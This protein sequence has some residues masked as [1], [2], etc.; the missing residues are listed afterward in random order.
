MSYWSQSES[1]TDATVGEIL[2]H[3]MGGDIWIQI[4]AGPD[5]TGQYAYELH[6]KADDPGRLTVDYLYKIRWIKRDKKET[7]ALQPNPDD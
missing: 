7:D 2:D 3:N 5:V 4:V 1:Y 6:Y